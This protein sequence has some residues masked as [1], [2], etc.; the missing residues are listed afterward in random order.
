MTHTW[1]WSAEKRTSE[2][3][4]SGIFFCLGWI[5][6]IMHDFGET[7]KGP[8][9]LD[10]GLDYGNF[11]SFDDNLTAWSSLTISVRR[12]WG[13]RRFSE[14]AWG[15]G[16]IEMSRLRFYKWNWRKR[17]VNHPTTSGT[18]RTSGYL[19]NRETFLFTFTL[20]INDMKRLYKKVFNS[21]KPSPGSIHGSGPATSTSTSTGTADLMPSIPACDSDGTMSAQ[22]AA[23]VRVSVQLLFSHP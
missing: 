1:R 19:C 4:N 22:V 21:K 17:T 5:Y 23:G 3:L 11:E 13:T 9:G 12:R 15:E 2:I 10:H 6:W 7:C 16:L 20:I 8:R 14:C 18:E